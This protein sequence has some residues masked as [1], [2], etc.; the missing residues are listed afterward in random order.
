MNDENDTDSGLIQFQQ[1]F[2]TLPGKFLVLSP[3]LNII[4]VSDDYLN[5]TMTQRQQLLGQY[6]FS[7]FPQNP[8]DSDTT[9]VTD[10]LASFNRVKNES[11]TD[12]MAVQRY[13]IPRPT[14]Q[15]G[16]FEERYWSTVNKGVYDQEAKLLYIV[17][18]IEDATYL[19]TASRQSPSSLAYATEHGQ[20]QLDIL[21]NSEQVRQINLQLSEQQ[22]NLLVAK[23][24][25]GVG[26]WKMD[27]DDR[28]VSWS[29]NVYHMFGVQ[30]ASFTLDYPYYVSLVHPDDRQA[31]MENF[32][33]F[34]SNDDYEFEFKHRIIR[35]DNS[36]I[37]VHGAGQLSLQGQ[38]RILTGVVQDITAQ[39]NFEEQLRHATEL[40]RLAGDKA[41]LGGWRV[42]AGQDKLEWSEQTAA[43]HGL[44][45][46]QILNVESALAF[47]APEYRQKLAQVFTRCM[48]DGTG[49]DEILQIINKQGE[50]VWVRNIGEAE[51]DKQGKIIAV[52]GAFQDISDLMQAKEQA[53]DLYRTLYTTLEHISDAF[54]TLDHDWRLRYI[55]AQGEKLLKRQRQ[56]LLGKGI[57]DEFPEAIGSIFQQQYEKACREQITVRFIEYF[58]PLNAWFEVVA[59]PV[60]DGLAVY[61]RDI[62]QERS[63]QQLLHLLETAVSIQNDILLIT[64]AEPIDGP[65]GPEIVYVNPAFERHTGYSMQEAIGNT[66]RMLQGPDTDRQELD[67]IRHALSRWQPV[68]AELLNYTKNGDP[69]WLELDIMPLADDKG[70]Y[71]HWV[72]VERDI[73]ARKNRQ[74]SMRISQERFNLIAQATNDVIWDWDLIHNKVWWNEAYQSLFG[75]SPMDNSGPESWSD[76][77]HPEDKPA[78]LANIHQIIEG[79]GTKW[80]M[81]YRFI[82]AQDKIRTVVD[83]GFVIRNNKG[84][85]V[86]MLGSML[87]ITERRELDEKLRQS[88]KLETIG[89]LTGGVAHDFNNLLTVILGNSELL[90]EQIDKDDPRH[91][92]AAINVTAAERGA[93]LTNRLLAY[94]RRQALQPK[95]LDINSLIVGIEGLLRRS[96]KENIDIQFIYADPLW[97]V[98]I[99]PGQMEIVLLNLVVNAKDAMQA[100]GRL[101]IETSN[102]SLKK[103][104]A[105]SHD[106]VNSGDYVLICVSDNGM[107][108]DKATIAQAFEPFF[109]TKGVGKGSGLGLSMVYGFIKQ[110]G[111]HA[112]IYSEPGNGTTIKLYLPIVPLLTAQLTPA[113]VIREVIGGNEHILVVEDDE[114]VRVNLL[115]QLQKLGYRVSCAEDGQQALAMLEQGQISHIDMLFTDVIM[116]G[117]INGKILAQ[118]FSAMLPQLKVLFTSGYTEN[119]IEHHGRLDKG[120]H[121]LSKPYRFEEM[122]HK[123]RAVLD[124]INH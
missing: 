116:P 105:E 77:I 60:T 28:H 20:E 35:P 106:E 7:V 45:A 48:Q 115:W 67:R 75:Y 104:Y 24:L 114:M 2:E 100:G 101:T 92:L 72:S 43:I 118:K 62:T 107:G 3:E 73:T 6:F 29:D 79:E 83:R 93:E 121:L 49:F 98:E 76:Y 63:N 103:N 119:A 74:E 78:V 53:A 5:T 39:V 117:E 36:V 12:I 59:Y 19:V 51:L 66:P 124:E 102:T 16:G 44:D 96:L 95:V 61:F 52:R 113:A 9:G 109:T 94:A 84:K 86:R 99:D 87:D 57:W 22:A 89:Q 27:L 41:K 1:L 54:I 11:I 18:R 46:Q 31:M 68:K 112:K 123:V 37:H 23:R 90:M 111:G 88:Q 30:P 55:N 71:T 80:Q 91:E 56:D 10:L 70:W 32:E 58:S 50:R 15:G 42:L 14:E 120:I 25:L 69:L 85:A 110:S 82:C 34:L 47:Y 97:Q 40:L 64:K 13:P 17:H 21:I 81:E 8:E 26:I 108:M 4:A 33:T 122:A 65:K 38:N